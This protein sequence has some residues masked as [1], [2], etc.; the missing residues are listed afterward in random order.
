[1]NVVRIE[2][3][4][5]LCYDEDE[6]S[7]SEISLTVGYFLPYHYDARPSHS[8]YV[9]RILVCILTT[10]LQLLQFILAKLFVA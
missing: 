4:S 2:S 10:V 8:D 5:R 1:M 6:P 7:V 9:I 3:I